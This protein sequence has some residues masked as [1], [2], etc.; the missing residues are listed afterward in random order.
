MLKMCKDKN[1][2]NEKNFIILKSVKAKMH[3]L[4]FCENFV[5]ATSVEKI[6]IQP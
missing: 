5:A 3:D 1:M 6:R 4:I 2:R